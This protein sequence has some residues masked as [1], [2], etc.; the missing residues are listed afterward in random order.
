MTEVLKRQCSKSKKG[1]NQVKG[2]FFFFQ[3]KHYIYS[4]ETPPPH[5]P[6]PSTTAH[7]HIGGE[8]GQGAGG[9]RRGGDDFRRVSG[10]GR[11][12]V[13]PERHQVR[14]RRLCLRVKHLNQ[15][16]SVSCLCLG[17]MVGFDLQVRGVSVLQSRKQFRLEV[18]QALTWPSPAPAPVLLL[19]A[20]PA[21][22]LFLRLV[23]VTHFFYRAQRIHGADIEQF[24]QGC[25]IQSKSRCRIYK[26]DREGK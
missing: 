22:H 12:E 6:P 5:T 24:T 19:S 8:G 3:I 17:L 16:T 11:E 20:L 4:H 10:S 2:V 14:P 21:H 7:L 23:P 25:S 18:L 1:Y 9:Q 26:L 13:H 15:S